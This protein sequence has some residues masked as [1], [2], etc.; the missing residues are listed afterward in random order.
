[1]TKVYTAGTFDLFHYGHLNILLECKKLGHLTVGV[2]TDELVE[3]YKGMKPVISLS[4]RY[5]IIKHLR[6]VDE[7]IVQEIFFDIK[8]L[9]PK[10]ID[11]IVLGSDWSNKPFPELDTALE[12]LKIEMRYIPY[13][14]RLS[15]SKIKKHIVNNLRI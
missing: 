4:D 3:S 5:A 9:K 1:M 2:S 13:T 12:M 8:Q 6:C 7:V 11:I 10:N 14:K 15:T